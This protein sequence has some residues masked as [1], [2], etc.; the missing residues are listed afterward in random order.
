MT[1]LSA[2]SP[3]PLTLESFASSSTSDDAVFSS[4]FGQNLQDDLSSFPP[5]SMADLGALTSTLRNSSKT[6]KCPKCNWHYKYQETL[7][8]HMKEKHSECEVKCIYCVEGRQHPRLARGETYSCGYKP[9]RCEVC[10][11]STTTKGNLSIHMQSDKHLHAVQDLPQGLGVPSPT[12]LSLPPIPRSPSSSSSI[13]PSDSFVCLICQVFSTDST[14]EMIAHIE[15]DRTRTI[16]S[17]MT[18][19]GGMFRCN[20]CPYSTP[21]K[22]NFHLHQRTDKHIQRIQMVSTVTL[23][24]LPYPSSI[25]RSLSK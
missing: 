11:Y 12:S 15:K 19:H 8:I 6:L 1:D 22:A 3:S 18:Q 23:L 7:E 16:G 14:E 17:D 2:P 25:Y 21:L 10:K 13:R 5:L 9:Y 24:S 20:I 4:F